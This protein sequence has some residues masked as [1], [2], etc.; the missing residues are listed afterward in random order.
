M[1]QTLPCHPTLAV[2]HKNEP[3]LTSGCVLQDVHRS[4]VYQQLPPAM[5]SRRRVPWPCNTIWVALVRGTND[6]PG[7]RPVV[8]HPGP[9][10]HPSTHLDRSSLRSHLLGEAFLDP[11]TE[12][13]SHPIPS[14]SLFLYPA[15]SS[16][17]PHFHDWDALIH[18][19][20]S[21]VTVCLL[22]GEGSFRRAGT[23]SVWFPA[24]SQVPSPGP[25][26]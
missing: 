8:T 19:C 22:K 9:P 14:G 20:V 4:A 5:F 3:T 2:T 16:P 15:L 21:L 25:G 12:A 26:T 6:S 11:P 13:V 17:L 23:L 10:S 7:P 18:F 24:A 1:F